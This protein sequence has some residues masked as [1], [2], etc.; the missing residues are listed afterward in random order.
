MIGGYISM[1]IFL[2]ISS[3]TWCAETLGLSQEL[4]TLPGMLKLVSGYTVAS[5]LAS[6]F[7]LEEPKD[8]DQPEISAGELFKLMPK[9]IFHK[10]TRWVILLAPIFETLYTF[11][12]SYYVIKIQNMGFTK[13]QISAWDSKLIV[14]DLATMVLLGKLSISE[15]YW[16]YYKISNTV[17]FVTVSKTARDY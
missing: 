8:F 1:N 6:I 10:E 2:L 3:K 14:L 13:E 5:S 17:C 12:G 15:K 16:H 9:I 7:L 4:I 11:V